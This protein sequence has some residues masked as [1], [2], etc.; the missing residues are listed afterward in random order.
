MPHE[1][2]HTIEYILIA[3]CAL[4]VMYGA[5]LLSNTADSHEY[6]QGL[7]EQGLNAE[8]DSDFIL[9]YELTESR[10]QKGAKI[11]FTESTSKYLMYGLLINFI[12]IS[13]LSERMN[14]KFAQERMYGDAEWGHSR[15][16][17]KLRASRR[18]FYFT[19]YPP[20]IYFFH[21]YIYIK[22]FKKIWKER[23]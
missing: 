21:L 11:A 2:N 16:F 7:M 20:F 22:T 4:A 14:K 10:A 18:K 9:L 1:K 23:K 15:Q 12:W 17:K 13:M 19:D 6:K 8:E 5:V 3:F